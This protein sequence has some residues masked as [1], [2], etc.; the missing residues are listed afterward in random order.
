MINSYLPGKA[1]LWFMGLY[2]GAV[3]VLLIV[4]GELSIEFASLALG[5]T[6]EGSP[7]LGI[8]GELLGCYMVTFGLMLLLAVTNPLKYRAVLTVAMALIA[9]RLIQRVVFA[10]K[11][12]EVFEVPEA[13]YWGSCLFVALLGV[14]VFLFWRQLGRPSPATA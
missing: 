9:V 6:V 2:H 11:V 1:L 4:S 10:D 13:R 12:I 3:G 8:A 14:G 7:A 5:Y